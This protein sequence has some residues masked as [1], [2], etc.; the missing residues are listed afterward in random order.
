MSENLPKPEETPTPLLP[1]SGR[2]RGVARVAS[3][4]AAALL[5]L[6]ILVGAG[7]RYGA[8]TGPGRALIVRLIDGMKLGPVGR[9]HIEG[10]R[11]DVF[12][13]FGLKRLQIVDAKGV[14]LEGSDLAMV[15][16]PGELLA[17]RFHAGRIG[18]GPRNLSQSRPA[19]TASSGL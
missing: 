14:W 10:L 12:R 3:L 9:L 15:W 13:S 18:A 6:A 4:A 1:R 19:G 8:E 17:R 11:G 7:V 16:E 2:W 5:A